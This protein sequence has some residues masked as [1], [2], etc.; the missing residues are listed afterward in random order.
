M[1]PKRGS[2][3]FAAGISCLVISSRVKAIL[4]FVEANYIACP[5]LNQLSKSI[6]YSKY[7]IERVLRKELGLPYIKYLSIYRIVRIAEGLRSHPDALIT[8]M[9]FD[10]NFSDLSSFIRSF[11]TYLGCPPKKFMNCNKDPESCLLRES[12]L[13]N[14]LSKENCFV[15]S[16]VGDICY[17]HRARI[18]QK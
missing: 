17:V 12:S 5:D 18:A 1:A 6:G 9:C 15:R 16:L 7:H 11:S 4:D 13:F 8:D 3:L 14:Q 2:R 10:Y